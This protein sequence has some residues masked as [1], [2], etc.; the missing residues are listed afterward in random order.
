[1]NAADPLFIDKDSKVFV[2]SDYGLGRALYDVSGDEPKKLWFYT[3]TQEH[4]GHTWASAVATDGVIYGFT[5]GSRRWRNLEYARLLG[6]KALQPY[7]D[8]RPFLLPDRPLTYGR[9][10]GRCG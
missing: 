5:R 2:S 10:I 8:R 9:C 4:G 7:Q 3:Q 6:R 1:M